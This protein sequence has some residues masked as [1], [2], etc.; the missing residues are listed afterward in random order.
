MDMAAGFPGASAP[1]PA[2]MADPT[3]SGVLP[4]GEDVA[5]LTDAQ[6]LDIFDRFKKECFAD[7]HVWERQWTR[8]IHYVNMRQWLA[9][10]TRQQGWR[11]VRLARGVPRPVT[12]KP[13]EGV[14]SIRA[15]FTSV[16][17]GVTV[18][19]VGKDAKALVTAAAA[20]DLSPVLHDIHDMNHVMNEFDWWFITTGNAILHAWWDATAGTVVEIPYEEC[21]NCKLQLLSSQ[22]AENKG[23]CTA[24]RCPK[25]TRVLDE[26]GEPRTDPQPMGQAVTTPL[27]MLEVAFPMTYARWADVPGLIRLRWR[28][29]RYFEE[30]PDLQHL[31][32][33][34]AFTKQSSQQ[35]LQIFQ[36]LP[37]Q[38]DMSHVTT[39]G[40][41]ATDTPTEGIAEYEMWLRPSPN[42]PEGLVL[43]VIG[44]S[45]PMV[46]RV[47]SEGLPGPLPYRDVKGNPLFTFAHAGYE[48]VGGRVVASG[49]LDPVIS[50][51]DQLNRLDS[52]FEMIMMRMA[53][54]NVIVAKGSGIQWSLESP[55]LPGLVIEWDPML[56]GDAGKPEFKPGVGPHA[57]FQKWREQIERDIEEGMGTYDIVK[58]SKP[59][60]VEAFS[61][62]QLL[63]ERGQSRFANAFMARAEAYRQWFM[64][65]L[66]LERTFGPDDRTK[67]VMTPTRSYIFKHYKKSQL[68]GDV[69][70]MVEDG[71]TQPK[72]QLGQRASIQHLNELK[73]MDPNDSDQKYAIYEKFGQTDLI[74]G[75]DAN[76]QMAHQKQEAFEN[77]LSAGGPQRLPRKPVPGADPA[78]PV[79]ATMPDFTDPGYPL[80]WR[81]W[82]DPMIHRQEFLKWCNSDRAMELFAKFPEAEGFA[83]SHLVEI[84]IAIGQRAMGQ[85][86]PGGFATVAPP[87][88]VPAGAPG[89]G[90]AELPAPGGAGRAM[91]NSNQN[92]APVGNTPQPAMAGLSVQ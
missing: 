8:N 10:W 38:N 60:G 70:I 14:Q 76:V 47:P 51:F 37:F 22:I 79:A 54:P 81:R 30:H 75:L 52:L 21:A 40:F 1:V 34:I 32:S 80:R 31:V 56:V 89:T 48:H 26:F 92:S 18:R 83:S 41:G 64:W 72:T 9:P 24:C 77:W 63:V 66:E 73:L 16:K 29:K 20:D 5:E 55:G 39:G 78:D 11:D 84:G 25:F 7:R 42:H 3:K 50:K 35:S 13:K 2:A 74:P 4:V 65:A 53:S 87:A 86:D 33:K 67:A 85:L 6:Y 43:R 58:G 59:T 19:P 91:A 23:R 36:S 82:W 68:T 12:S 27:S 90:A 61:A 57:A 44:D 62:L 71:S 69:V 46:L 45:N 49:A 88:P 28:D 17:L 15:M